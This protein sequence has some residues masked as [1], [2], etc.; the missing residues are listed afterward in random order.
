MNMLEIDAQLDPRGEATAK[1]NKAIMA[2]SL[3]TKR[4]MPQTLQYAG[5]LIARSLGAA[6]KTG[7]KNRNVFDNPH[8]GEQ[9]GG[10]NRRKSGA[11]VIQVLRQDQPPVLLPTNSKKDKRRNIIMRGLGKLSF[12]VMKGKI[13]S[14]PAP[15]TTPVNRKARSKVAV[16][17]RLNGDNPHLVLLNRLTYLYKIVPDLNGIAMAKAANSMMHHLKTKYGPGLMKA[18]S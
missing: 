10:R 3:L 8:A 13:G 17:K 14:M 4:T 18:W 9:T 7:K 12:K 5:V 15:G 1:L 11:F 6:T 16:I 2:T